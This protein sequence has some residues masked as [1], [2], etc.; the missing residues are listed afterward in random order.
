MSEVGYNAISFLTVQLGVGFFAKFKDRVHFLPPS[1]LCS[2]LRGLDGTC[3]WFLPPGSLVCQTVSLASHG[4]AWA[5]LLPGR[6]FTC[7]SRC[8]LRLSL[9]PNTEFVWFGVLVHLCGHRCS[10]LLFDVK[11]LDRR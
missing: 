10:F 8:C 9:L 5:L 6:G 11:L 3:E 2:S 7:C 1:L 4:S